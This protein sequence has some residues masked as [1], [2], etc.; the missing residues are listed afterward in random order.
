MLVVNLAKV[1]NEER[2][3]GVGLVVLGGARRA[4][5]PVAEVDIGVA[6]VERRERGEYDITGRRVSIGLAVARTKIVKS[7]RPRFLKASRLSRERKIDRVDRGESFNLGHCRDGYFWGVYG[8]VYGSGWRA[9]ALGF[10]EDNCSGVQ[11]VDG[12]FNGCWCLY[13]SYRTTTATVDGD[14]GG[15]CRQVWGSSQSVGVPRSL[16]ARTCLKGEWG[17][18][19]GTGNGNGNRVKA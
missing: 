19:D 2:L 18:F 14:P 6:L 15:K 17:V 13:P 11:I 10:Q 12:L 5:D 9:D 4:H 7:R 16:S 8:A 1:G 3:F